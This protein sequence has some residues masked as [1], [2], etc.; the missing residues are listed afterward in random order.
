MATP[1]LSPRRSTGPLAV[2]LLATVIFA[3]T[4]CATTAPTGEAAPRHEPLKDDL[5]D[6][7]VGRWQV[8]RSIRGTTVENRMEAEWVLGHQFVRMHMIDVARP[9]QYEAIV[10]IGRDDTKGR[11][12]AHWCDDFGAT[13]SAIGQGTR[14]GDAIEFRFDYESGPF[15]NTFTWDATS[16]TW[17][18][19]GEMAAADGARSL[20]AEDIVR[21]R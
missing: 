20:F 8:T 14:R 6:H 1:Y 19:R 12:V 5:L 9:P 4:G 15:F 11:Y 18:F 21:R 13:Y 2:V 3:A 7:L 17:R 16:A 10:L